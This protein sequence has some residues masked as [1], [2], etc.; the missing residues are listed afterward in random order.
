[1]RQ[2]ELTEV[3]DVL[4]WREHDVTGFKHSE[5]SYFMS[6]RFKSAIPNVRGVGE[7]FR[8]PIQPGSRPRPRSRGMGRVGMGTHH[9]E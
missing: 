2:L 9:E 1:M 6:L 8:A 4:L 5:S 7:F 3:R